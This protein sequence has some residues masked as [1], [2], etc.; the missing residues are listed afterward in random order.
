MSYLE[1]WGASG[2]RG[3]RR[4][5]LCPKLTPC[6][7]QGSTGSPVVASYL[8]WAAR[9]PV[10]TLGPL[11]EKPLC[12]ALPCALRPGEATACEWQGACQGALPGLGSALALA[13]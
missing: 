11:V 12:A 8:A 2:Q 10:G 5:T 13:L 3:S 4:V 6:S 9:L 1:I 7:S